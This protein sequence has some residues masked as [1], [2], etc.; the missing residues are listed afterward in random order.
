MTIP[1]YALV[2]EVILFSEGRHSLWPRTSIH[3]LRSRTVYVTRCNRHR[4]RRFAGFEEAS[5][6]AKKVVALY[7]LASEQL[8]QQDHYDWGM[9]ALKVRPQHCLLLVHCSSY[10]W[11]SRLAASLCLTRARPARSAADAVVA[12]CSQCWP[13]PAA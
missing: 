5:D 9:R 10:P 6:L 13:W 3:V 11:I 12:C 8:S 1:D 2:A 4:H 7:R